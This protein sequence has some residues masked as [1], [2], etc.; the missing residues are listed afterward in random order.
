MPRLPRRA[1]GGLVYHAM[2]RGVGRRTLF[3]KPADY[4]AFERV[5]AE[6]LA[7]RRTRV[8]TY[9][10]MPNH[11]H[12]V[13][14]PRA[15]GE[16]SGFLRW[17]ANTHSQRHH[18]HYHTAGT[19]HL[20]QGRFKSFPVQADGPAGVHFLRTCRY[21][22]RNT[23]RARLVGRAEE[24][25]WSSL[26]RL[27]RGAESADGRG[28]LSDWPVDRP[29]DWV[30]LVNAPQPD[31]EVAGLRESLRRG[32]PYGGDDWA[33]HTATAL[34]LEATL[35]PRG[36]PPKATPPTPVPPPADAPAGG[37]VQ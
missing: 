34:G 8:L 25:P 15:D 2:N 22:E 6:A 5:M 10:L 37:E 17:L 3:Y 29:A 23:L 16:M 4:E 28:L 12:F 33:A 14:W 26:G 19:G 1:P 21:V 18:A 24:W 13:L 27:T 7:V 30:E 20:Y 36:R 32:R 35:R 9:C 11:W 31:E